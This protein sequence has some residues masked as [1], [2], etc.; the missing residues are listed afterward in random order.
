MLP[1]PVLLMIV[2]LVSLTAIACSS[3]EKGQEG[4]KP[5]VMHGCDVSSQNKI[6][7]DTYPHLFDGYLIMAGRTKDD[8][9]IHNPLSRLGG[10][11]LNWPA[12]NL[13]NLNESESSGVLS[14]NLEAVGDIYPRSMASR[15]ASGSTPNL[16]ADGADYRVS[17]SE[18]YV[19]V[20]LPASLLDE[21]ISLVAVVWPPNPS[22]TSD[23]LGVG[24]VVRE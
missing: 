8:A 12:F 5:S 19:K 9:R 14:R 11:G 4:Y 17:D 15:L 10:G 6:E 20:K 23:A 16:F 22:P 7:W 3:G 1:T 24:C 21:S 13:N 18:F 2:T